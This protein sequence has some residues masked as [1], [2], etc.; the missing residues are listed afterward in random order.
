M[1]AVG[2]VNSSSTPWAAVQPHRLARFNL[3]KVLLAQRAGRNRSPTYG[4][5][6]VEKS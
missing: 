4:A 3:G 5:N 1:S 2:S 6:G